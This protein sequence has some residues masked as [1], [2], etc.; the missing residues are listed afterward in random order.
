MPGSAKCR[1]VPPAP[2]PNSFIYPTILNELLGTRFKPIN[3]YNGTGQINLALE[4][5]EVMGRGGN[6]W[7]SLQASNKN[8]LDA[9]KLNLLVQ[10][11]F[12]KEP[13]LTDVPLLQELV[14]SQE[15]VQIAKVISLP[16]VLGHAHWVA[17]GVPAER[18]AALRSAYAETIRDP[19]FLREAEKLN[20]EIRPQSGAQVDDLV[21]QVTATPKSV[22]ARTAQILGWQN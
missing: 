1:S 22:L 20:M 12:E 13:E 2:R 4:R 7:A 8:W 6:S 5:G 21:R 14:T 15:G 17:P 10:I 16:T 3:G 11:G 18:V 9:K 19:E